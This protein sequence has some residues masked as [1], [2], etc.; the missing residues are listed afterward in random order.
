MDVMAVLYVGNEL[1]L[2]L[3]LEQAD[4]RLSLKAFCTRGKTRVIRNKVMKLW[5]ETNSCFKSFQHQKG[6]V[7]RSASGVS[8]KFS[9]FRATLKVMPKV[10]FYLVKCNLTKLTTTS[11]QA[12]K[13]FTSL[14]VMWFTSLAVKQCT[15][16]NSRAVHKLRGQVVS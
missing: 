2:Q 1:V 13:R 9:L 7:T 14:A 6:K 3:G 10:M 12:V 11:P 15:S 4:D 5:K 16:F 8:S